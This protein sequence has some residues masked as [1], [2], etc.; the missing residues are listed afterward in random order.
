[1]DIE[2]KSISQ[3]EGWSWKSEI[4]KKGNCS[5]EEYNFY[6]LHNK[7]IKDYSTEDIY[8][9]IAQE[10]GLKYLIPIAIETLSKDLHIQA[11]DYPTD[12]LTRVLNVDEEYWKEYPSN[13]EKLSILVKTNLRI[14]DLDGSTGIYT[15]EIIKY[16]KKV[17]DKFNNYKF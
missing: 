7:P 10:S 4:P 9:M 1:M 3:L 14:K 17:L 12:L 8:F 15:W 11:D 2:R 6:L 5:Y 16:L 13:Y